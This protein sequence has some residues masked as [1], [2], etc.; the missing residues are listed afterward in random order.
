[1]AELLEV[2]DPGDRIDFAIEFSKV[3]DT[4]ETLSDA[5]WSLSSE[6]ASAGVEIYSQSYEGTQ[7]AVWLQVASG[8]RSASAWSG[9]GTK[10]LATCVATSSAGRI[11]ERGL[12]VTIKQR[13]V[14]D[15]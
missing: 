6:A 8:S 15:G 14:V 10:I 1:M 5:T 4:G 12:T 9:D 2:M 7:A 3:L 13:N 11:R